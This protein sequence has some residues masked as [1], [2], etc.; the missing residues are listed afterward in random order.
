MG[1]EM[2]DLA[3]L[4]TYLQRDQ[5]EVSK[6]ASRGYLPGQKVKGEWRFA[7][8]EINHWIETQM[9][10]YT[11]QE[12]T[13]LEKGNACS[14]EQE[15]LIAELL[16]EACVAVPLAAATRTSISS[17]RPSRHTPSLTVS[18]TRVRPGRA[19]SAPIGRAMPKSIR[20]PR[21]VARSS[22]ML[23]GLRSRWTTGDDEV[24]ATCIA[25][26][27]GRITSRAASSVQRR[28]ATSASASVCPSRNSIV[29]K[30]RPSGN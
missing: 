16:S 12:L 17:N 20:S 19:G 7:R 11:E 29:K 25:E 13:A 10:A 15:P 23:S 18:P 30:S 5:R 26:A 2:M 21:P 24:W 14:A 3:E 28:R 6:M 27:T 9:H 22:M 4:A 8:A 1:S